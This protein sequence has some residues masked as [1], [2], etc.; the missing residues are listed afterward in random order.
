MTGAAH[1]HGYAQIRDIDEF[2]LRADGTGPMS[3]SVG[4]GLEFGGISA[5]QIVR[6]FSDF[7]DLVDLFVVE[8]EASAVSAL[9]DVATSDG[10]FEHDELT[11]G[12]APNGVESL[13]VVVL[14]SATP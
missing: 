10:E 14:T 7:G 9:L 13:V 1:L 8:P 11:G 3:G 4:L 5:E 6:Q 12:A 2:G